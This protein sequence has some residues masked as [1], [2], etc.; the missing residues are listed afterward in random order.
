[1]AKEV[2]KREVELPAEYIGEGGIPVGTE[3]IT[4]DDFVLPRIRIIQPTS[5][6]SDK[7]IGKF[8]NSV[9]GEVFSSLKIVPLTVTHGRVCFS[10]AETHSSPICRSLDG[11]VSVEGRKC[12][13]CGDSIGW[14]EEQPGP[15]QC[16]ELRNI[17]CLLENGEI[18]GLSFKRGAISEAK[19]II[20][21]VKMRNTPFFFW[22][23]ELTIQKAEGQKGVYYAPKVFK[24]EETD[25]ITRKK[26]LELVRFLQ[27][28]AIDVDY[29]GKDGE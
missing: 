29:T 21:V 2:A 6:D 24:W 16:A 17:P 3:N 12:A 22:K 14:T 9:T 25:E 7:G 11:I 23:I 19:R 26:A 28:K 5:R 13:E 15:P 20:T 10:V 18:A 8:C 27:G 1:M 4:K